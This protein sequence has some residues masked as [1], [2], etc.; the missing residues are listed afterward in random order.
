[1]NLLEIRTQFIK[2]SGRFDLV[3]N[4]TTFADNGADY[5]I[6]AGQR[7]LDGLATNRK[8]Q[9]ELVVTL[10]QGTF[11][12]YLTGVVAADSVLVKS[13]TGS[14]YLNRM[15]IKDLREKYGYEAGCEGDIEQ[16]APVDYAVVTG[17]TNSSLRME[18]QQAQPFLVFMPP[19]DG[20]Y[21]FV[22]ETMSYS[23]AL[24]DNEDYNFW[25]MVYPHTLIQAA[26]YMIERA[27]RNTE[28]AN[29]HLNAILADIRMIDAEVVDQEYANSTQMKD[30]W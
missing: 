18:E 5:Y 3:V 13:A 15:S 9:K 6:R 26:H 7:F 1:M 14:F 28:G 25:S 29:D 27:Y 2:E 19:L 16:G 24:N 30:S 12:R 8:R 21:T 10:G 17:R 11:S 22:I 4:T 20:D 23:E